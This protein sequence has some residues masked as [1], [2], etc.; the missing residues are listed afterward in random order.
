MIETHSECKTC[1]SSYLER[2]FGDKYNCK[3]GLMDKI[4]NCSIEKEE[5]D[6]IDTPSWCPKNIGSQHQHHPIIGAQNQN[7]N[8]S[9]VLKT[10][11]MLWDCVTNKIEWDDVKPDD[12]FHVPPYM[13]NKRRDIQIIFKCF[14]YATYK[15]LGQNTYETHT[16]YPSDLLMKLIVKPKNKKY[17]SSMVTVYQ[18]CHSI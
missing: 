13:G 16:I 7:Q 12:I 8:N 6:K 2:I 5:I 14:S 10:N 1:K 4:I 15:V 18:N 11:R 9:M 3:C 17:K